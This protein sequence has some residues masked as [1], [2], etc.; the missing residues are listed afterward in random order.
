MLVS[1]N[2]RCDVTVVPL[3]LDKHIPNNL[4][5][6]PSVVFCARRI[7]DLYWKGIIGHVFQ[8]SRLKSA[9]RRPHGKVTGAYTESIS[10]GPELRLVYCVSGSISTAAIGQHTTESA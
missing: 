6:Y 7:D 2:V 5:N 3:T 1:Y 10:T 9:R 4:P 8:R